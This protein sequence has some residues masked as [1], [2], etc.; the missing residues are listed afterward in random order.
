M[1][2]ATASSVTSQPQRQLKA[3]SIMP[4]LELTS[5][6][7]EV[8]RI[9]DPDRM[10][11]LQ[12]RRFAGC[13]VCRRHLR[14]LAARKAEIVEAGLFEV[15]L[16]YSTAEDIRTH[17][18]D[19]PFTFVPDPDR[20]YY[21]QFAVHSAPRSLLD[22]RAWW[23]ILRAVSRSLVEIMRGQPMPPLNPRGGRFG[24]PADFLIA[25][26]GRVV[27]AKYGDYVDDQWSADEVLR[28]ARSHGG[29]RLAVPSSG[30]AGRAGI[31]ARGVRA[32]RRGPPGPTSG[33]ASP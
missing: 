6:A 5:I 2:N 10:V 7:N 29:G 19:L 12:F 22:P 25:S 26:D 32:F 8:V 33:G 14:A 1:L 30:R 3:G 27:A 20:L 17:M 28:L 9:P 31:L 21:R 4:R 15:V 24:L 23:P 18:G 16:F 13:P 11:H